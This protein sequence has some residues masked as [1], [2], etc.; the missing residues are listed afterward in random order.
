MRDPGGRKLHTTARIMAWGD[1][2]NE[3]N[4]LLED[5]TTRLPD[6]RGGGS[7]WRFHVTL[8]GLY[9]LKAATFVWIEERFGCQHAH[10]VGTMPENRH[11]FGTLMAF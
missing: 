11:P 8:D 4:S 5:S 2:S 7:C 3:T 1:R 6:D 9:G 10:A